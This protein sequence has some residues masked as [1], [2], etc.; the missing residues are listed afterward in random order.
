MQRASTPPVTQ[1]PADRPAE[2]PSGHNSNGHAN[3][4]DVAQRVLATLQSVRSACDRLTANL[5][6]TNRLPIG[7]AATI[8]DELGRFGSWCVE[9]AEHLATSANIPSPWESDLALDA[10]RSRRGLDAD[11]PPIETTDGPGSEQFVR[12]SLWIKHNA[13]IREAGHVPAPIEHAYWELYALLDAHF[14]DGDENVCPVSRRQ[15]CEGASDAEVFALTVDMGECR[16]DVDAREADLRMAFVDGLRGI[17][18]RNLAA[19]DAIDQA[20]EAPPA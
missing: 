14:P 20:T 10:I 3:D 5:A 13:E 4:H 7:D 1:I 19:S 9:V 18:A 8:G 17:A 6:Q 15:L 11:A 2:T 16:F 12:L